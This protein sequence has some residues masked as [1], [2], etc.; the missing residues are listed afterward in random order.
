MT[1]KE[2]IAA[3]LKEAM[4]ARDEL[5]VSTLRLIHSAIKNKE[6]DERKPL[7]D[8][9]VLAVLSTAAKQRRESIEQYEKGGRADLADKEKAELV[10]IQT[11]MPEQLGRDEVAALVRDAIAETSAS[12]AKDMGKVMKALMPKVKG[13]ADGKLVNELVKELLG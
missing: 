2:R 4:K 7:E 13:K 11:F 12:G 5:K 8:E 1:L 10:I 9:G 3:E 6:I